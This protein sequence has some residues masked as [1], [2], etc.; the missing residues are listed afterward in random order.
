MLL[1]LCVWTAVFDS[2]GNLLGTQ[3]RKLF[4]TGMLRVLCATTSLAVGVNLPAHLVVVMGT[5]RWR[6]ASRGYG[7]YTR[8]TLLQVREVAQ[9]GRRA[10]QQHRFT[11][12]RC[13]LCGARCAAEQAARATTTAAQL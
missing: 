12:A 11:Y 10:S 6:G 1:L 7:T 5:K 8:A 9:R 3:L 4:E 2:N 13:V